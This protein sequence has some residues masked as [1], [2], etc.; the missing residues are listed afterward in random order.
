MVPSTNFTKWQEGISLTD[1]TLVKVL[2]AGVIAVVAIAAVVVNPDQAAAILAF[3]VTAIGAVLAFIQ[4][5]QTHILVNSNNEKLIEQATAAA[6]AKGRLDEQQ[7]PT[8]NGN[9]DG[10]G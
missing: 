6:Y 10:N 1:N 3:A 5:A 7:N 9:G 8:K 4:S 2:V